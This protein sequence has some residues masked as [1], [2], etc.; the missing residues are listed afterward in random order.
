[1]KKLKIFCL[2]SH[3]TKER[4]SGVDFVRIIQPMKQ[5]N[6]YKLGD[7]EFETY[8]YDAVKDER[9][10]WLQVADYYDAIYMN[11]TVL[12]WSF[13]EMG[14]CMRG[15]KRKIVFDL[16]DAI[17]NMSEDNSAYAVFKTKRIMHIMNC[18]INEVDHVTTTNR[19][20]K[21]VICHNTLKR[22]EQVTVFPNQI[23]LS[24]YK[25][26]SP[27]KE[28][29]PIIIFH[30]GSTTH[31]VDLQEEEFIKAID[32]VLSEYPNVMIKFV[33]AFIP[34]LKMRWGQRYE[35]AFGDADIYKWVNNCFP[36]FMDE[37]DIMVAPLKDTIYNRSKSDIKFIESASA[38]KP[39]VTSAVRPYTDTII[40]GKTGFYAQRSE[41]W[42][43]YLAKLIGDVKLRDQIGRNAY[44]YIKNERQ[45][46]DHTKEYAELFI[47]VLTK[48]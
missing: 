2:P 41:D 15:K 16:D 26:E 6:G 12:D 18:I 27:A 43:E 17:W 13:A 31:F 29:N 32:K 36:K 23:D 44:Q 5:L 45:A 9:L 11:Y 47:K 37:A 24:F 42:Y 28:K 3:A 33:G 14:A 38:L 19:Y 20:L 10:N 46:K 4:T 35:T 34:S 30:Y 22:H 21:N 48:Q 1:M 25:H 39:M 40:Q 7:Y 8:I